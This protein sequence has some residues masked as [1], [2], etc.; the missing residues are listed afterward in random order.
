[1]KSLVTVLVGMGLMGIFGAS[2]LLGS[3]IVFAIASFITKST[4]RTQNF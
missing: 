4:H 2:S 3:I 1:M